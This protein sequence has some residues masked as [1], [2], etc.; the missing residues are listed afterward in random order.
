MK[1]IYNVQLAKFTTVKIGGNAVEMLIPETVD[2]LSEIVRLRK[3]LHFLGG[4]SNLLIAEHDFDCVVN[5]RSFSCD[6]VDYG[7]GRF[8]VGASV[9]LQKLI[10]LINE[11]GRGGIEYLYSVPGCVGGAIVQNAGRGEAH[12]QSI[13]DYVK[14][15]NL[16]REDG[17]IVSLTKEQCQFGHRDS[18]FKH[19]YGIVVS[20][21]FEF[22]IV[23]K[24]TSRALKA[25]RLA[26]C[27][28]EQ[29][30]SKPNFGS[31]FCKSDG[32]ILGLFRLLGIGHRNA[33]FSRKTKNWILNDGGTFA[34]VLSTIEMAEKA[35]D[36]LRR[37]YKREVVVW[38]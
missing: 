29:D 32:K 19:H 21:I 15:V 38:E 30:N 6:L 7:N 35:H 22:P 10:N 12:H 13:S 3:P 18:Y 25:E 28:R 24:E 17:S 4:G 26:F 31:V 1:K 37:D 14:K 36:L 20:V 9:R 5:L 27:K 33:H 23:D 8:L 16:I 11:R 2:E 34:D